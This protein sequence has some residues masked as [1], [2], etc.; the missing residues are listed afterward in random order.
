[1]PHPKFTALEKYWDLYPPEEVDLPSVSDEDLENLHDVYKGLRYFKQLTVPV[2]EERIRRAR[3]AYYGM[4]TELYEYV[5]WLLD[6]LRRTG[7]L[8]NTLVVYTSDHGETLGAHGRWS[9]NNMYED[10][11]HVP[12]L[13]AGPGLPPG[14]AVDTPVGHVDMAATMLEMAG[15]ERP[16][17]LRGVSLLPAIN[18][19]GG[20]LPEHAYSECH[21]S[22]NL[23][24]TFMIR[25]G[26]WKYVHFTW[27]DG[28][29]FNL[30]DDPDELT[31]RFDDPEASDVLKDL[32]RVLHDQVN[33]EDVTRRAFDTQ[34][35]K[36]SE[37]IAGKTETELVRVLEGRLGPG[38]GRGSPGYV[39]DGLGP[40][41]APADERV[42]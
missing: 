36:L 4:I 37:I 18:G 27:Y 11:V 25:S 10:S 33:P 9:K 20:D 21:C 3:A 42:V 17:T 28:L 6:A 14:I 12:M 26:D 34:A 22:G 19:N 7:Q 2:P 38:Q 29:L 16:S 30:A 24:G 1:L 41:S 13:M 31:N 40:P 15:A 35:R 23:T 39:A 32:Q 5:G 8:D